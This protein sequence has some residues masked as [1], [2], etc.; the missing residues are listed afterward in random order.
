MLA[1]VISALISLGV[2]SAPSEY[3]DSMFNQYEIQIEEA[4]QT[5]I[6]NLDMVDV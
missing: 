6:T 3:Q 2:I 5:E 4:T 1:L